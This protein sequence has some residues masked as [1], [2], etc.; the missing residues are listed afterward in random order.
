V[1]LAGSLVVDCCGYR[2]FWQITNGDTWAAVLPDRQITEGTVGMNASAVVTDGSIVAVGSYEAQIV[3]PP[4]VLHHS[5]R[6]RHRYPRI[7]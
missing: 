1:F 7:A 4:P 2:A 6:H 3:G 5:R